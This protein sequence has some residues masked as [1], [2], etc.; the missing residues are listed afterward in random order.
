M[1]TSIL[2]RGFVLVNDEWMELSGKLH[3]PKETINEDPFD[4][5]KKLMKSCD[6]EHYLITYDEI[7]IK[8]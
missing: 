6:V 8:E 5:I 7:E 3:F 4:Y 1:R 2:Y